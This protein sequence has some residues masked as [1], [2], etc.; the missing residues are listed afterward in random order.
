MTAIPDADAAAQI[1]QLRVQIAH[2]NDAYFRR[3]T[4]IM[5]DAQYDALVAQ[6]RQ[7]EARY[8]ALRTADSPTLRIAPTPAGPFA[9]VAH[10]QPMLSLQNAFTPE[11]LADFFRRVSER[12]R[13]T[14]MPFS[15]EPK[16]DGL[17]VNLHYV[18]G[19]LTQG[20]TR[21]DGHHGEDVTANLRTVRGVVPQLAGQGWPEQLDVRGEVI[22]PH[23]AFANYN[24]TARQ[25]GK[26]T[27]ANPRN[28]AAGGLRQLDPVVTGQRQLQFYA[29]A[30]GAV[31]GGQL[32]DR[33]SA[34][35]AQLSAWGIATTPYAD[36]AV[37][38]AGLLAYYQRLFAQRSQLPFD[39]D[40]VVYKLDR[41]ADQQQLGAL[42]RAPRWAIAHKFPAQEQTT[43]VQAIVIQIGRTGAAT[44]VA[45]LTPVAVGGVTVT[46]A[47]LH[48][49]DQ[50]A[51][52]D[53]RVGDTVIVRRAGDVIPEV[54]SVMMAHRP[55]QTQPWQMPTAC[56]VCGSQ[57][58]RQARQ[59]V[60]RCSGGLACSAQR[61]ERIAH[62]VSRRAMDVDGMGEIWID[63]LVD[64]HL[65]TEIAD[66]YALTFD[67]LLLLRIVLNAASPAHL[68][69]QLQI[70]LSPIQ[71]QQLANQL[72]AL[73]PAQAQSSSGS[74]RWQI[75]VLR[76]GLPTP[77]WR[78]E[79]VA[80]KWAENLLAALDR[81][82]H[83][84]LARLLYAL[85]ID[86]VGQATAAAL[87]D[88]FG[89]L[90]RIRR[91]PWPLFQ[92]VPDIGQEVAQAIGYF[93]A[94]AGNQQA[95]DAL[96]AHGVTIDDRHRPA[97][98]WSQL[99][100]LCTVL[101]RLPNAK[102][103]QVRAQQMARLAPDLAS[104]LANLPMLIECETV[105]KA[106]RTTLLSGIST[107]EQQTLARQMDDTLASLQQDAAR[108]PGQAPILPLAGQRAVLTGRLTQLTRAEATAQLQALG[109]T[110]TTTLSAKT[111]FVVV[112]EEAGAKLHQAQQLALALWHEQQL[113]DYLAQHRAAITAPARK[114]PIPDN[115]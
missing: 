81:S 1:A 87:A 50:V 60:W 94:Q 44:P 24:A 22:M 25:T 19:Q 51:R 106:V 66:L 62:F 59:T 89:D 63:G 5:P 36:Q 49:A 103:S 91:T 27:L 67:R 69:Q 90:E 98:S 10:R 99:D 46:N 113:L 73:M 16:L 17:A 93:F 45:R 37:G 105:P 70:H 3:D 111:D 6:L 52:L 109:A 95:I 79:K 55:P 53:V 83:T 76:Q 74:E 80:T 58:V 57:I 65:V 54:V 31:V 101:T 39:I 40:G 34:I 61:K 115:D 14:T 110:V 82:R 20:T 114:T 96:L 64:A 97:S 13:N 41:F 32:P 38:L 78:R 71:L 84:T 26:K 112:G 48:N 42:A 102:I 15:V 88:W 23:D 12:L 56:P 85:G 8:P 21:G 92:C 33:Q 100:R 28:G 43:Q 107:P 30:V 47:T 86:H 11:E 9:T 108:A 68:L 35:L 72:A 29:Y 18:Q 77:T 4:L 104:L 75:Q 2:A 7:L